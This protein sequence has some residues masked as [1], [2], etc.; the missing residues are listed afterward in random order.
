MIFALDVII[1]LRFKNISDVEV[2]FERT[3]YTLSSELSN[4]VKICVNSFS[5]G[6]SAKFEITVQTK[7]ITSELCK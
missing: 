6:T 4:P 3:N 5:Q 2:M 7:N 1:A